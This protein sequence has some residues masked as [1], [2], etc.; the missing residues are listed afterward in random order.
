MA[1]S[2]ADKVITFNSKLQYKGSLPEG[3]RIMNPF[4]ENSQALA[5]SSLFYKKYYDDHHARHL[6]LGINPGR[7]GAGATGVPFTDPKRLKEKCGISF[8]GPQLHEPSSVFIYEMIDAYGGAAAFYRQYY[9]HSVCP[10]GFTKVDANGKETNYNYF[11]S[12]LLQNAVLPFIEWNIQQQINMGCDTE[13]CFCLGRSKNYQFLEALNNQKKWF[14]A[15]IP[16]E[17]PRF[18]MQYKSKEK[19]AYIDDYLRKL[20]F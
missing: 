8:E 12:K 10:L 14:G 3:I 17:H 16:L 7:L 9:I 1:L 19:Q 20:S 11:D 18:I 5:V 2:F 6:I 4:R 13:I 15:I